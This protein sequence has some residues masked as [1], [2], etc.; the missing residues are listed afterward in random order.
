MKVDATNSRWRMG[1]KNPALGPRTT[2][3][4]RVRLLVFPATTSLP[5]ICLGG[6][7]AAKC[8]SSERGDQSDAAG[9]SLTAGSPRCYEPEDPIDTDGGLNSSGDDDAG[10]SGDGP[11]LG[12]AA[13]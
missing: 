1:V 7:Y 13:R 6:C 2:V 5:P 9:R 10:T 8:Q 11:D 4:H 3:S 12:G